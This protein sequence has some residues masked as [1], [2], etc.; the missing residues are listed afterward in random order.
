MILG[1]YS[2]KDSLTGFMNCTLEQNDASAIRNFEHA[3]TR[4]DSLFFSHP[5]HY[6]L[7]KLGYFDTSAGISK[8]FDAIPIASAS[9]ILLKK[10]D[11]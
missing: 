1:I 5:E 8:H 6:V 4:V 7:Y 11:E 3:V 2:I 10:G 9:D